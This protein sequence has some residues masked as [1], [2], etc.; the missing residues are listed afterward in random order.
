MNKS[1]LTETINAIV[2]SVT[3]HKKPL[4]AADISRDALASMDLDRLLAG[5]NLRGKDMTRSERQARKARLGDEARRKRQERKRGERETAYAEHEQRADDANVEQYK[6][7]LTI[8]APMLHS[9]DRTVHYYGGKFTNVIGRAHLHEV[10]T[11]TMDDLAKLVM[12]D[13]RHTPDVYRTAA[14]GVSALP[15]V[16]DVPRE[17]PAGTARLAMMLKRRTKFNIIDWHRENPTLE[18]I[19]MLTTVAANMHMQVENLLAKG[20]ELNRN[21]YPTPGRPNMLLFRMIVDSALENMLVNGESVGWLLDMLLEEKER[22][23]VGRFRWVEHGDRILRSFSLPVLSG[24]DNVLNG[25]YAMKACQRVFRDLPG[26]VRG[27]LL[28]CQDPRLLSEALNG[29]PHHA[30]RLYLPSHPTFELSSARKSVIIPESDAAVRV[31]ELYAELETGRTAAQRVFAADRD[32]RVE[33]IVKL[34]AAVP[35]D[36]LV[37]ELE[38]TFRMLL[39]AESEVANA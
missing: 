25:V 18:S 15:G 4:T 3:R 13:E 24:E 33:N 16:P 19:E 8:V 17:A 39:S 23:N 20:S 29:A 28:V 10:A 31:A 37:S 21:P 7:G 34:A 6:A 30:R 32:E 27:A 5:G 14:L 11:K 1:P 36:A 2:Q 22:D 12:T 26:V 38:Y 35:A 9:I